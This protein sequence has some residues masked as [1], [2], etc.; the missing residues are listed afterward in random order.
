MDSLLQYV[1]QMTGMQRLKTGDVDPSYGRIPV[2]DSL[3]ASFKQYDESSLNELDKALESVSEAI[4][5]RRVYMSIAKKVRE[6][7]ADYIAGERERM[8]KFIK[9]DNIPEPGIPESF[10]VLLKELQ[11]LGLDEGE[12]ELLP[13]ETK[14]AGRLHEGSGRDRPVIYP[15]LRKTPRYST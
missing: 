10:K 13:I 4:P 15:C 12:E 5:S 1:N 9:G 6:K 2:I 3:L 14:R 8:E 7:G 11:S